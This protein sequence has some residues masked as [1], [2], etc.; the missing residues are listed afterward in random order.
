MPTVSVGIPDTTF[1]SSSQPTQNFSFYPLM[2]VGNDPGFMD[3]IGLMEID[4]PPL[5]VTSVDSAVLQLSVIVKTGTDPS[6]V[7][8]NRVTSFF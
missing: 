7:V 3:C 1:V 5:P 2:Y 4:L 6:P 8:V